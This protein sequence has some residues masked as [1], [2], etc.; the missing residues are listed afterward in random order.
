MQ[1]FASPEATEKFAKAI[2]A[3]EASRRE[4]DLG[5]LSLALTCAV[6]G[7]KLL[8]AA[9]S[10]V[11]ATRLADDLLTE[12]RGSLEDS[13]LDLPLWQALVYS[14]PLPGWEVDPEY[15][16]V[17]GEWGEHGRD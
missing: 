10:E 3:L 6:K 1:T 15:P 5:N 14:P 11:G 13:P 8:V 7:E 16:S 17:F 9:L 4:R 2:A 12:W